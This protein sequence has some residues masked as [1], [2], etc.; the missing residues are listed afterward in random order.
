MLLSILAVLLISSI[1]SFSAFAIAEEEVNA[2]EVNAT[3]CIGEG[4]SIPV[5]ETQHFCCEGLRQIK[6]KIEG[7]LGSA[8]ICTANCGN[9]ICNSEVESEYNCPE[10]CKIE[11]IC[12]DSD[13]GKNVEVRGEVSEC[14]A[15]TCTSFEDIC[16]S[17]NILKEGFCSE[18]RISTAEHKCQYGCEKGACM[19][20]EDVSKCTPSQC[21]DGTVPKCE[22]HKGRCI[23]KACPQ[24]I[25]KPVCG[26]GI[27][28]MGEGEICTAVQ[29]GL[30][31]SYLCEQGKEC[32]TPPSV[33]I[34]ACPEDCSNA[35][36]RIVHA[37]LNEKFKLRV[38]QIAKIKEYPYITIIFKDLISYKCRE[39]AV[40]SDASGIIKKNIAT[41]TAQQ[42][43]T[44]S[45]T[46]QPITNIE[47]E[48]EPAE[49]LKCSEDGPKALLKIEFAKDGNKIKQEVFHLLLKE[50]KKIGDFT[51]SF[52]DYD[53]ASRTGLFLMA[54]E[55]FSCP[56]K[57]K[58]DNEGEVIECFEEK[59]PLKQVLCPDG[60]CRDKCKISISE[61]ECK[62]GCRFEGT[63]FPMSIR[64][65]GSYC[66]VNLAMSSQKASD[67][68]CEN[69]F[70]CKSNICV[71]GKCVSASLVE[72]IIG[73]FRKFFGAE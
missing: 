11:K 33:C 20:K 32:K 40:S 29:A 64:N 63:C 23:C 30:A 47:Y 13:G 55:E 6:P 14:G 17:Y 2:T 7:I 45:I 22:I 57:C 31:K 28:E 1:I 38:S 35:M 27:C 59:C 62:Y 72:K 18:N 25:V 52:L 15:E 4:Q 73:W 60:E 12:K 46:G 42:A 21:D 19:L 65:N 49:I 37:N 68:A 58:C 61:E 50:K 70:E 41:A 9:E 53:Y 16:L 48:V 54:K 34:I 39:E 43:A 67:E 36:G 10:D 5:V 51:I 26:N 69:N 24:I 44:A 66:G 8:G 56:E 3:A 71:G